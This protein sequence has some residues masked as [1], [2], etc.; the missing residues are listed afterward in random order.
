VCCAALAILAEV[1]I[2]QLP[3]HPVSISDFWQLAVGSVTGIKDPKA[4][5]QLPISVILIWGFSWVLVSTCNST[6]GLSNMPL[7]F[8]FARAVGL[9]R[10]S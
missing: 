6:E 2:I 1:L 4:P 5:C 9:G 7:W 8:A 10:G 3:V